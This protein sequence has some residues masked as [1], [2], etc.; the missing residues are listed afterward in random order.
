MPTARR[1]PKPKRTPKSRLAPPAAGEVEFSI[2]PG[3]K[4]VL[5]I[6][7]GEEQDGRIP[8][9]VRV[10]QTQGEKK[11]EAVAAPAPAGKEAGSPS[12]IGELLQ[13]LRQS[14]FVKNTDLATWLF[15][16]A[17]ALYLSTRLIGLTTFPIFFFVDEALQTQFIADLIA[18][19]YR[20]V[21]DVLFP[22]AFRNG[23]YF[24]LGMGVYMQWLPYLIFG[25]SAVV[26]RATS[27]LATL[28]AAASAGLLLRDAFKIKYW[29][30]GVLFL[31]ITPT[32][33]LH[34][35]TAWEV[36][37]FVAFYTGALC[38]YVFYR[39]K[40]PRYLYLAIFLGAMG[41]YTYSPGQVLVPFTALV[42][43]ALDWRYHWDQRRTILFG[44]ILLS[45]LAIPYI[46]F[47]MLD[48]DNAT[49][50]L[51]SLGSYL[52]SD[53]S[54]WE[55]IKKYFSEYF[56]GLGAWYWYIPGDNVLQRHTMKGYGHIL[57]WTLPF[58]MLGLTEAIRRVREP[59]YRTVLAA[60]LIS[61][62]A[63]ALV[64]VGITRMMTYIFPAALFTAIGMT[65]VL[66]WVENPSNRLAD[67]TR[68]PPPSRMKILASVDILIAGSLAAFLAK[69]T[70]DRVVVFLLSLL[71]AIQVSGVAGEFARR[72]K[73]AD[74]ARRFKPW[75]ISQGLIAWPVFLL[76]SAVN[77]F[78]FADALRNGPTWYKDY[79]MSGLQYGAFQI[80][81][82]IKQYQQEHPSTRVL[83][84]PNW[85]NG[86][87]VVARFFL[88]TP[89]PL[90]MHSIQGYVEN[91]LP[92]GEDTLFIMTREEYEFALTS[93]KLADIRVEKTIPYPDGTPGFYF[94]RLRYSDLAKELFAKEKEL[95][96]IMPESTIQI[97]GEAVLVRHTY[98][99]ADD[100]SLG[101]YQVFDGDPYTYAK[102]YEAN[103]FVMELT[104]PNPRTINGFSIRIG[105]ANVAITLTGYASP[106]A[107]PVTYTFE[108]QGSLEEPELSFDL[109]ESMTVQILHVEQLDVYA[110]PPTKNH[111]WELTLR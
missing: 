91:E 48:P 83:F 97:G 82:P 56:L 37:E 59:A 41:F 23:D 111:V 78:M 87:D 35:R 93:E 18:N 103:P 12:R 60:W 74:P 76:L 4:T 89:I 110:V 16:G 9:R 47:R 80:F 52:F 69:H 44:L 21:N 73:N 19:G 95:R 98:L 32:W 27:A 105:S 67:L 102:T 68:D 101:I 13:R 34:S 25:K 54:L 75:T 6:E 20:G 28:I 85:A 10:E 40:S 22:P 51:H 58:A 63:T 94:V 33:F 29:W 42:F 92:M 36:G 84:S 96:Q 5:T 45:I 50:H 88:G 72:M 108:G 55:K 71:L 38:A 62:V 14:A 15:W 109:P 81:E 79:G 11:G 57:L 66:A 107:E 90:E 64:E 104:F 61:P 31:S 1:K 7:A 53:I 17:L 70:A 77:V 2:K 99:D 46:R 3:S 30:A 43:I 24:T 8:V 26:T 100:Q 86:T 65:R 39:I 49:A 106:G